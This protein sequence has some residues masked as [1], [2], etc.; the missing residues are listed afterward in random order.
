MA[1]R[2]TWIRWK[3]GSSA[4]ELQRPPPRRGLAYRS[5]MSTDVRKGQAPPMHTREEFGKRFRARFFDPAFQ[6]EQEAIARLEEIAWQGYEKGRKAPVTRKAGPEF[7]DPDYDLSVEWYEAHQKLQAA[8]RRWEDK[9]TPSQ[10]L[11][12]CCAPRN[13]GT[14]PGEISKTWRLAKIAQEQL[15]AGGVQVD[16]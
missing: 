9:A 3:A 5:C 13:D 14:C 6:P 1:C 15:A 2:R 4:P 10:V 11:V 12:I 16:F 8:Q 7:K